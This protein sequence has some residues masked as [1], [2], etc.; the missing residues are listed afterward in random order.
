MESISYTNFPSNFGSFS[1]VW[2]KTENY[3]KLLRIFLSTIK[4]HSEELV[5][6]NFIKV[7][8]RSCQPI[9]KLGIKIQK[10]FDG[11]SVDFKLKK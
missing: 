7:H 9:E 8:S 10:V 3:L 2:K 5:E 1:I 11:E 6:I 4:N